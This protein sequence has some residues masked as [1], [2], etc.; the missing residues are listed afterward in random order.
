MARYIEAPQGMQFSLTEFGLE[1]S[2]VRSRYEASSV[3]RIRYQ[4]RVPEAWLEKGY[5]RLTERRVG[6]EG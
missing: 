6:V 5:V 1:F 2:H 3:N 4:N